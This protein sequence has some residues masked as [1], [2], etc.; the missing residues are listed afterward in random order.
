LNSCYVESFEMSNDLTEA[1]ELLESA[2]RL[3]RKA[4]RKG[5]SQ[6]QARDMTTHALRKTQRAAELLSRLQRE[7]KGNSRA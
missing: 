4:L 2:D 5:L 7:L 1:N 3:T 6:Q